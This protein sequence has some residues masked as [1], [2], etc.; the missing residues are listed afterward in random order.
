MRSPANTPERLTAQGLERLLARLGPDP[1]AAA[2]EYAALHQRLVEYFD[3]RGSSAAEALADQT[4][5]RV[6]VRLQEDEAIRQLPAFCYGVARNVLR[7]WER[8]QVGEGVALGELAS[9][10]RLQ[11][12]AEDLE[13][14]EAC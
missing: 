11:D 12:G 6:T 5:D 3:R 2:R 1:D 10:R 4:L 13:A 7:E 14:E 9:R 8:A